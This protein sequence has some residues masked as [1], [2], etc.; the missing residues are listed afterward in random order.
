MPMVAIVPW[1]MSSS[2]DESDAANDTA[3]S[4]AEDDRQ[5]AVGLREFLDFLIL[6]YRIDDAL[7]TTTR[8]GPGNDR[9]DWTEL[10][11]NDLFVR[12][13]NVDRPHE[14]GANTA[15]STT[16][17][18]A[19]VVRQSAAAAI[20][21]RKLK[22]VMNEGVLD[23]VLPFIVRKPSP[24]LPP[25]PPPNGTCTTIEP[26]AFSSKAGRDPPPNNKTCGVKQKCTAGN[27]SIATRSKGG[28]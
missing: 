22:D 13:S 1:V 17:I 18:A 25:R 6:A 21:R 5:T 7:T 2:N 19:A 12:L 15:V 28:E 4:P 24:V 16:T 8:D 14:P 20:L 3:S 23:S 27:D 10:S 26:I 9:V 11:R